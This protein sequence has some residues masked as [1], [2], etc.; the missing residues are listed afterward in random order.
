MTLG[1]TRREWE[2]T[3]ARYGDVRAIAIFLPA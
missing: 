3:E 2:W 1:D